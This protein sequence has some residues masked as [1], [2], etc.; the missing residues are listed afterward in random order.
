MT[1]SRGE[2]DIQEVTLVLLRGLSRMNLVP[3]LH[4]PSLSNNEDDYLLT[5]EAVLGRE[6]Y[7]SESEEHGLRSS[8]SH[9][10]SA[11]ENDEDIEEEDENQVKEGNSH[12]LPSFEKYAVGCV[13]RSFYSERTSLKCVFLTVLP[14]PSPLINS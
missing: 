7:S 2:M 12:L 8:S 5:Q 14:F 1:K 6:E 13:T 3:N 9:E 10:S 4:I 11:D